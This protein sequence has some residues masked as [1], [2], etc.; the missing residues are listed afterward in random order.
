[1]DFVYHLRTPNQVYKGAYMND[2]DTQTFV[3]AANFE[4]PFPIADSTGKDLGTRI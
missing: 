3:T 2:R 1:M 4:P